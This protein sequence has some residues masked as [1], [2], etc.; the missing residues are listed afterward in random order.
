[1]V[2]AKAVA[3]SVAPLIAGFRDFDPD[4]TIVGVIFNKVG[5]PWHYTLL[6]E[7]CEDTGVS[8]LG[9]LPKIP[10]AE[11]PSRHLGLNIDKLAE[12]DTPVDLIADAM[13]E[14]V[15]WKALLELSSLSTI[16]SVITEDPVSKGGIRFAVA[17]D[18]AF[19]FI[20]SQTIDAMNQLGTVTYFSP[21]MDSK[22]PPADFVY[23]PGGYPE[24][25][26]NT[27]SNNVELRNDMLAFDG[28][29][30]AECGGLMYL[31]K[32][33]TTKN[34]EVFPMVGHFDFSTSMEN[35]KLHLGYR[36]VQLGKQ[37][38]KG[39]EFHYSTISDNANTDTIGTVYNARGASANTD[40]YIKHNVV[41]TYMHLY[42]GS[43]ELLTGLIQEIKQRL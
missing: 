6:K 8:C 37:A 2:D 4:V 16:P 27:L 9:Y 17:K 32:Q 20:Y 38:L 43:E 3:Y 29:I 25:H 10:L 39:H 28:C 13:D 35:S 24:H 40:I 36:S 15:D 11:I 21:L 23:L 26:A 30:F 33:L 14:H 31:G 18:E 12:F 1:M 7:A 5:S 19:N 41:A 34:G 42:L 22:L